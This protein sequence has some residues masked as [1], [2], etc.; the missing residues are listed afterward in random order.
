MVEHQDIDAKRET[1]D[2]QEY[3]ATTTDALLRVRLHDDPKAR[4]GDIIEP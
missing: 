2:S 1:V 3:R 4:G